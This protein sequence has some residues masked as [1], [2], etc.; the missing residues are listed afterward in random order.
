MMM[1]MME[2]VACCNSSDDE[3]DYFI[4]TLLI[5][6]IVKAAFLVFMIQQETMSLRESLAEEQMARRKM[7]KFI[8]TSL[9]GIVPDLKWE[10]FKDET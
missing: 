4:F 10:E 1:I 9:K 2:L 6:N 8:R 3:E 5:N 7:E